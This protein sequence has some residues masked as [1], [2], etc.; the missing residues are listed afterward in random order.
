MPLEGPQV[1]A[2]GV[3]HQQGDAGPP[4]DHGHAGDVAQIAGIV[5]TG[6]IYGAYTPVRLQRTFH[7][8]HRGLLKTVDFRHIRP[9]P[10]H[11]KTEEGG[12]VKGAAV[13][14]PGHQHPAAGPRAQEQHGLDTQ[15]TAAAA[16]KRLGGAEGARRLDFRGLDGVAAVVQTAGIGQL[17]EVGGQGGQTFQHR[18]PALVA[19]GVE[20]CRFSIKMSADGV[21]EWRIGV[22]HRGKFHGQHLLYMLRTPE[23]S[24]ALCIDKR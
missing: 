21:R 11:V 24:R 18:G 1:T 12:G 13:G 23:A 6:D 5:G 8:F 4:A 15:G 20:R 17:G 22:I 9:Q 10:G 7:T 3:I 2:V 16:E 19:R 14:V